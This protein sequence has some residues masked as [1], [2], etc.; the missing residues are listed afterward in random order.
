M[1]RALDP[2]SKAGSTA[3]LPALLSGLARM[4]Y[5]PEDSFLERTIAQMLAQQLQQAQQARQEQ[6]QRRQQ[7]EELQRRQQQQAQQ[8]QALLEQQQQQQTRQQQARQQQQKAQQEALKQSQQQQQKQQQQR[9]RAGPA[10][11]AEW[12]E[13]AQQVAAAIRALQLMGRPQ[14]AEKLRRCGVGVVVLSSSTCRYPAVLVYPLTPPV[15]DAIL[16]EGRRTKS[17]CTDVERP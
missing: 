2:W 11:P 17:L 9:A 1:L 14:A 5:A 6:R 15:M 8:R 4:G 12:T 13:Q 3:D 10:I 16:W 7:Q